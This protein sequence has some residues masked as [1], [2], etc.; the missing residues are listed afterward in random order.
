MKE[1]AE[2][3]G[4][5]HVEDDYLNGQTRAEFEAIINREMCLS[6]C[7]GAYTYLKNILSARH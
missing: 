1:L 7:V 2:V 6:E 4:V 3:S 5:L